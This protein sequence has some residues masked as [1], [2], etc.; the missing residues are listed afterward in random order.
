VLDDVTIFVIA[1][2]CDEGTVFLPN[3]FTPNG[4][5]RN[6]V[7]YVRS[8]F[9]TEVYLAYITAGDNGF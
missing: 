4:D 9:I 3:T 7:L 6:D 1:N 5:G 2:A 8:N